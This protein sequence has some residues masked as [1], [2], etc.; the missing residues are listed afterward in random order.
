MTEAEL[1]LS[2][3][4]LALKEYNA[5]DL[6]DILLAASAMAGFVINWWNYP[7]NESGDP[8]DAQEAEQVK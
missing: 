2:C 4:E 7:S 8:V 5:K 3:L 1:R 6:K